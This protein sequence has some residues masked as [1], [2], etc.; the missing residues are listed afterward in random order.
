MSP[1]RC[2]VSELKLQHILDDVLKCND[3]PDSSSA[4]SLFCYFG[5][6]DTILMSDICSMQSVSKFASTPVQALSAIFVIDVGI[7]GSLVL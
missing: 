6:A 2:V 1:A 7:D 4:K 3:Q 5:V